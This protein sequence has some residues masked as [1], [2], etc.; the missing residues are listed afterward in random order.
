MAEA[1]DG[2]VSTVDVY[3]GNANKL[4][5]SLQQQWRLLSA[6]LA[7]FRDYR[8]GTTRAGPGAARQATERRIVLGGRVI[9]L[10]GEQRFVLGVPS[11]DGPQLK[12]WREDKQDVA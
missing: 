4:T 11:S 1:G 2:L 10:F 9:A 3:L 5:E 7:P 12:S 8:V 6:R